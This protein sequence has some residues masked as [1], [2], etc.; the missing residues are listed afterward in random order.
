MSFNAYNDSHYDLWLT[1]PPEND[2]EPVE[3]CSECGEELFEGEMAMKVD[4]RVF[5]VDC[6]ND[7]CFKKFSYTLEKLSFIDEED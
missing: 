2:D 7:Y 5:C 6:G 3:E 4:D 1:T